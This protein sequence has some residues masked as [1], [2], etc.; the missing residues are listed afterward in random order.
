MTKYLNICFL[1]LGTILIYSCIKKKTPVITPPTTATKIMTAKVNGQDWAM[2]TQSLYRNGGL[3][4][5]FDGQTNT[6]N[7]NSIYLQFD[8]ALGTVPL[9]M[10]T[11]VQGI[12]RD[13]TGQFYPSVSGILNITALD[14]PAISS[15]NIINKFKATFS[16]TT[17]T[18]GGKTFSVTDGV[19][20]FQ[21]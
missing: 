1:F 18:I 5:S 2:T 19:V 21:R 15:P 11:S 17:V 4:F 12:Y 7:L 14:T 10:P 8:Y 3:N 20:N 9:S 13:A 6:D 16:F